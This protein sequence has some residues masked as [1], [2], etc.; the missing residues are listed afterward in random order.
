METVS[1][2]LLKQFKDRMHFSHSSEDDNLTRL[3]SFS[4]TAIKGMIGDRVNVDEST[5]SNVLARELVIERTR[6]AYNE[7]TEYFIE[8]FSRDISTAQLAYALEEIP[9]EP[10]E[11][12]A[13][14]TI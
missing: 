4:I 5:L 10:L 12:D 7:A 14:A 2:E 1:S 3:L 8:N 9:D 6:Y 11:G 13:D